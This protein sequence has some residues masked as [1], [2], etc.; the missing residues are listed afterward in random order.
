LPILPTGACILAGI[1]A[2]VPVVVDIGKI[3]DEY[4]PKNKT[5]TLVEKWDT[6]SPL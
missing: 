1:L 5:M 2:Q 6:K 3:E 4:E